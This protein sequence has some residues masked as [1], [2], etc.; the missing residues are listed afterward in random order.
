[1]RVSEQALERLVPGHS[2]PR[3]EAP[4]A[5]SS[6]AETR[7]RFDRKDFAFVRLAHSARLHSEF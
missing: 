1:M 6:L 2:R 5:A 3:Q 7:D 4:D